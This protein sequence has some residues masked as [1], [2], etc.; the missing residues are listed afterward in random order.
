[1]ASGKLQT[2]LYKEEIESALPPKHGRLRAAGPA[3]FP[4]DRDGPGR[5]ARRLLDSKGYV[6][7][8]EFHRFACETV[9]LARMTKRIWTSDE[10]FAA[11]VEISHF[12]P[13]PL[14]DAVADWTI[15]GQDGRPIASGRFPVRTIPLGN[16]TLLGRGVARAGRRCRAAKS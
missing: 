10:R 14:V 6:T 8:E 7:A 3:R 2:L 16:G 5:R 4:A 15:S 12:G 11:K 13:K 1:M 9:P